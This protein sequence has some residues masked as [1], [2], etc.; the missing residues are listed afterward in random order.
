MK[1]QLLMRVDKNSRCC[2][3][4]AIA[5]LNY[6]CWSWATLLTCTFV[7][8]LSPSLTH[9]VQSKLGGSRMERGRGRGSTKVKGLSDVCQWDY[10]LSS[11][12]TNIG[13]SDKCV[14][15]CLFVPC[16]LCLVAL[17]WPQSF[18]P[19]DSLIR[20]HVGLN[21]TRHYSAMFSIISLLRR[22]VLW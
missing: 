19:N 22:N 7:L 2:R 9:S 12:L 1:E 11:G 10:M 6:F 14:C 18:P 8:W 20:K 13:L 21:G 4:T 17:W 15:V 5:T 3:W 16:E